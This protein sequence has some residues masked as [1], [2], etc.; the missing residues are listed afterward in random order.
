MGKPAPGL[1]RQDKGTADAERVGAAGEKDGRATAHGAAT[2]RDAGARGEFLV[3]GDA[4]GFE[5]RRAAAG[6]VRGET[7]RG[8]IETHRAGA[9]N[10][11][12]AAAGA[13]PVSG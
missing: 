1:S 5:E 6:D 10:I 8:E 13:V 4:P 3:R 11:G 7:S 9:A 2:G 12:R